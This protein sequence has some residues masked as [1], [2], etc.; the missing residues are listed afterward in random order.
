MKRIAETLI[1]IVCIVVFTVSAVKLYQYYAE[2]NKE[3][4]SYQNLRQLVE[5]SNLEPSEIAESDNQAVGETEVVEYRP[6]YQALYQLNSDFVG[7]IYIEGTKIDYPVMQSLDS[8]NF[9]L[10]HDFYKEYSNYG[11]P[12]V[13]ENCE[14]ASPSDNIIIYS[15]HMKN[16]SMFADLEK[17]KSLDF[18]KEHKIVHFDT[19]TEQSTYEILS[20]FKMSADENSGDIF[21][22]YNFIDAVDE[23]SFDKFIQECK[24]ISIYDTGV[25][26]A[27][28]DKIISLVTCEYSQ[29][30]GR[31]VVI[32]K[33][34]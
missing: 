32:A 21:K 12:Y 26:A 14:V 23:E 25:E 18:W 9:Y 31:M 2:A 20:V 8:P 7:W 27:F 3:E 13:Q 15:H 6:D 22:F 11:C 4:D 30:N 29:E 28:G 33:K 24:E 10:K 34:L 5:D 17:Y 16:G 1:I 19:L